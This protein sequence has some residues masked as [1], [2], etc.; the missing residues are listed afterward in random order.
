MLGAVFF[1]WQRRK[2]AR[3]EECA[4]TKETST[5]MN[6]PPELKENAL[7]HEMDVPNVVH[8]DVNREPNFSGQ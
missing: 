5:G 3:R 2:I 6:G 8:T 7:P 4:A 1:F